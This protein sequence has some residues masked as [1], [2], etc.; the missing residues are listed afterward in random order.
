M[1]SMAK[2]YDDTDPAPLVLPAY[3]LVVPGGAW[4]Y[5]TINDCRE[6]MAQFRAN[7]LPFKAMMR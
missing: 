1:I 7:G 4:A 5:D 3:L 6:A 2:F